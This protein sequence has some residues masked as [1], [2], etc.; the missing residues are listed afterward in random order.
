LRLTKT[1]ALGAALLAIAGCS[2][3][4]KGTTPAK[5]AAPQ[6][7]ITQFYA[8]NPKPAKGEQELLC[9]GVENATSVWLAPPRTELSPALSRCVEVNPEGPT[10]Y[11]LT[12][13]GSGGRQVTQEVRVSVGAARVHL[14]E[15]RVSD[16]TVARGNPVSIC[17]KVRNAKSVRIVPG[18]FEGGSRNDGCTIQNPLQT[19]TYVVTA[20]GADG[21]TD[22]EQVTVKIR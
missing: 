11:T 1:S 5:T 12:A 2:R 16:L 4:E 14:V 8:T 21:D 18:G 19:T 10:T 9:Y 15:V 3:T 13:Q 22:R 20:T 6:V 7:R 17:Y